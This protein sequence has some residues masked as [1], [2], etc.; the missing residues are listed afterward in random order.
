VNARS[1]DVFW[2]DVRYAVR[3]VRRAPAF[4]QRTREIGIRIALGATGRDVIGP[5]LRQ[6]LRVTAFG[7]TAGVGLGLTLSQW[8]RSWL[9]GVSPTDPVTLM[10]VLIVLAAVVSVSSYAPIKRAT[11]VD[12]LI[13]LRGE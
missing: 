5:M 13:A 2:Q 6:T 11:R 10:G 4:G 8:L 12:P 1:I 3:R 9:Y 7:L